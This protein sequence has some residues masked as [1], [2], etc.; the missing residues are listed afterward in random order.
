MTLHNIHEDF[1]NY[2]NEIA[3]ND[4]EFNKA[5]K[6]R[7]ASDKSWY[8]LSLNIN[9]AHLCL[10]HNIKENCLKVEMYIEN[11]LEFF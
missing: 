1:W 3:F 6:K 4:C 10:R 7:K 5:F 8:D 11:N 2:F 9:E